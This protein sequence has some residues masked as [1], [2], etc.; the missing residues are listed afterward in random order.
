MSRLLDSLFLSSLLGLSA[1][2]SLSTPTSTPTVI[3]S[4]TTP[5]A[6]ATP[7]PTPIP[8][9]TPLACLNQPG[10]VEVGAI[11]T[12]KP[13]QEFLVYLPPCYDQKTDERYPVLYLLH[14]QTYTDDEWVRLGAPTAADNL[15]H[16]G[17]AKP[18]IIVFPDDRYWNLPPES[19]FG[20]RVIDEIIP[21]IDQHYRTFADRSHRAVGGLSLG[22][23]WAIHLALTHY[24]LFGMLGLHSPAVQPDDA[25]YIEKWIKAVPSDSWPRLWIDAGDQDKEL[26]SIIQ[27]E[28]LLSYYNLP[29]EWHLYTGDHSEAYWSAHVTEYLQWYADGW[30]VESGQIED[31]TPQP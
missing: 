4:T 3:P 19:G 9:A 13:A 30:K 21:Y 27:F 1:C 17:A 8:T 23:G 11:Q 25:P 28:G 15:I 20:N 26:G 22:G 18:F 7:S 12:T 6:S 14:G 29:H 16:S 24:D 10:H 5:A 2:S 31:S